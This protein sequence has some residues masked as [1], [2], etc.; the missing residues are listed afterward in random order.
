MAKVSLTE[1]CLVLV[2]RDAGLIPLGCATMAAGVYRLVGFSSAFTQGPK[3]G[4]AV[5]PH[6]G[7]PQPAFG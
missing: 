2:P 4:S 5:R 1:L 7:I 6:Q 3:L